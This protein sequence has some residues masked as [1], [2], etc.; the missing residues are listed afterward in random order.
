MMLV[1]SVLRYR[2]VVHPLKPAISSRKTEDHLC[3]RVHCWFNSRLWKTHMANV[4]KHAAEYLYYLW[5]YFW[6]V[7]QYRYSIFF[8]HYLWE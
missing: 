5:Q 8:P 4:F 3:L 2:A 1:I 6:L 7:S